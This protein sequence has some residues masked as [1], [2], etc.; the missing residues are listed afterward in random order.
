MFY[1]RMADDG[2]LLG[3]SHRKRWEQN[4]ERRD[5]IGDSGMELGDDSCQQFNFT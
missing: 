1:L 3:R 2:F 4:L 5:W